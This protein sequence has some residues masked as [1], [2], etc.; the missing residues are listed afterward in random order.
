MFV[1]IQNL[2]ICGLTAH[3]LKEFDSSATKERDRIEFRADGTYKLL[4]QQVSRHKKAMDKA[5]QEQDVEII[6][7]D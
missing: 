7:L 3:L 5:L 2:E 1:S 4:E 6:D